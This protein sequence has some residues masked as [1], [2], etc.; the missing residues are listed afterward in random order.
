MTAIA[1]IPLRQVQDV[2]T[3]LRN[4][5]ARQQ[6]AAVAA[7]HLS[8]ERMMRVVAN[9]IR[10]TPKLQEADP[11]SF[12]GALMQ[13]ASLGLEPNT[14][15][16]QAYLVPF[17]NNREGI[18]EVQLIIGYKGYKS[19]AWRS[20]Q[21]EAMHADVV[22]T[23]DEEWSYSYGSDMHVRHKPGPRDGDKTHAYCFVK[24][25][26]GGQ[27]FVVMPWTHILRVRDASQNWKTAVK[28]GKTKDS[29]WSTHEDTMAAKTA[30]RYLFQRGDV[31]MSIEMADAMDTDHDSGAR[32][33]YAG[34]AMN[35]SDGPMIEGDA[36]EVEP[37]NDSDPVDHDDKPE[38]KA[39]S[40]AKKQPEE[41]TA[42]EKAADDKPKRTQDAPKEHLITRS[43]VESDLTDGA[44]A[45]TTRAFHAASLKK[46]QEEAPDLFAEVDAMLTE[47][48]KDAEG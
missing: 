26:D 31:P 43:H 46:M 21:I 24:L 45:A 48:E 47:A 39:E 35:P 42:P 32:I 12:L 23:D 33:D 2:K 11:L 13:S 16:G 20:G 18:T 17:R 41:K 30:V 29:P 36:E 1:K 27:A 14:S 3:L 10:T 15:M 5:Q 25:K 22:Y 9:A 34:F 6:L 8:P 40:E 38:E 7:K 19:L 28:Y 44:P 4:D 37:E